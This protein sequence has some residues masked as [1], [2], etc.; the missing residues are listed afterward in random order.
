MAAFI[1]TRADRCRA[2]V[3]ALVT[4]AWAAGGAPAAE[5]DTRLAF[6][7]D[8]AVAVLRLE[9]A[10][11]NVIKTASPG[12]GFFLETWTT[13][14]TR[15]LRL[16][17]VTRSGDTLVVRRMS[18]PLPCFTFTVT[19]GKGYMGLK[20]ARAEG[21]PKNQFVLALEMSCNGKVLGQ[22][23][24]AMSEPLGST[25]R[26]PTA[27]VVGA[28]WRYLWHHSASAP[29]GGMAFYAGGDHAKEDESLLEIWVR[30]DL[31]RPA[32]DEPWTI[33]RAR[34]WVD[35]YATRFA[36]Q[37][38]MIIAADNPEDLYSMA[39]YAH[40]AGVKQV[41]LH[42]DTWRGEYWPSKHSH[43]HVNPRVFPEGVEDVRRFSRY[44][45]DRGMFLA[46][47]GTSGSIGFFD[48]NHVAGR[49]DP[50]LATWG[51][52]T[53]ETLV[54]AEETTIRFKPNDGT[55]FPFVEGWAEGQ[56]GNIG[57]SNNPTF[58][59]IGDEIIGVGGFEDTDRD[60]WTL[61]RCRRGVGATMA[62]PHH[63][64]A[65]AVGLIAP[66]GQVL[67]PD[68]DGPLLDR[69]AGEFA[70]FVNAAGQG[71]LVYDALEIHAYPRWGVRAF[72][73]LVAKRLTHPVITNTSGGEPVWCNLEER[74]HRVTGVMPQRRVGHA[75]A[76]IV[77]ESGY[78]RATDVL[79]FNQQIASALAGGNSKLIFQKGEA[80]FGIDRGMIATHGLSAEFRELFSRWREV[81][82]RIADRRQD[83]QA[84][85]ADGGR[86]PSRIGMSKGFMTVDLRETSDAYEI[87]PVR[88]MTR[89]EGDAP[90]M[91]GVESAAVGP[92]QFVVP[93]DV[94]A[95]VN[96]FGPQPPRLTIRVLPEVTTAAE[97]KPRPP[98]TSDRTILDDYL[99]GVAGAGSATAR[100]HPLEAAH[101][102]WCGG[103]ESAPRS[104]KAVFFRKIVNVPA[105]K[106]IREAALFLCGD[107]EIICHVNGRRMKTNKMWQQVL[108]ADITA[109]LVPGDNLIAVEVR[110]GGG[111]GGGIASAVITYD[112]G[113][114]LAI[115]TDRTW[116]SFDRKVQGWLEPGFDDAAWIPA[117]QLGPFGMPPWGRPSLMLEQKT[118]LQ[119]RASAI[120]NQ[121]HAKIV[122]DGDGVV[123]SATNERAEDQWLQTDFPGWNTVATMPGRGLSLDVTGDGSGAVL[124]VQLLGGGERD[125]VV[126][127]DFNGKRT[128]V[129]PTGEVS[130][131]S[132]HWGRRPG[133]ERF[134]YGAIHRVAMGFGFIPAKTSP[135]V[136][137]ENLQLLHERESRITNP[138]VRVGK[139]M[140]H[141]EGTIHSG[142]CFRYEGGEF[143]GIYDENWKKKRELPVRT[144][145]FTMPAGTAPVVID[146]PEGSSRPWLEVQLIVEGKPL[147]VMKS[148][149]AGPNGENRSIPPR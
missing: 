21:L 23:L 137:V 11:P 106:I 25:Q 63:A 50:G 3:L 62:A 19:E 30:E 125:Y 98:S 96:P 89:A 107:D 101:W 17:H 109:A 54:N 67:V 57:G 147:T 5:E 22:P 80:M 14:G 148:G 36:D 7:P 51:A 26:G 110:N 71:S 10:G 94:L 118:E 93:G 79:T 44:L 143:G 48:P 31:P 9:E 105:T 138:T 111:E 12:R 146:V 65:S 92:R 131:A 108:Y 39:D 99:T 95:L 136:K 77:L 56:P 4:V 68:V 70:E 135:S 144:M 100:P 134:A 58:F 127:I 86:F 112:A 90:W 141:I 72:P 20:L 16:D 113:E 139:G 78:R 116:K 6:A 55:S 115:P 102:I 13:F 104:G 76:D 18:Q 133:T 15:Q 61:T 114:T 37:T 40:G 130:W 28:E 64:G 124:V 82:P 1:S 34:R 52:G 32:I 45:G 145:D 69:I 119:P 97:S 85:L 41:Y 84:I 59:R 103:D 83:L 128:I 47:H 120:T 24:D 43:V 38:Q 117:V 46:L 66:Y 87:V 129:I 33:D 2:L 132:G 142:E 88:I 81:I 126:K 53:L 75:A 29:A 73:A 8:G 121:R 149:T 74:F 60:V 122:E 42:T 27:D 35:D 91:S 49:V 140:L 123:V